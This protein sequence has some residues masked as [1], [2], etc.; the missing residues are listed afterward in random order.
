MAIL[1]NKLSSTITLALCLLFS[2]VSHADW[3]EGEGRAPILQNDTEEARRLA[4]KNALVSLMYYGGASVRS[5]QVVKSGVLQTDELRV[6]THGEVY[7]LKILK[8][9]VAED[10]V[11]VTIAADIFPSGSCH[12]NRYTKPLLVG[13]FQLEK[14]EH[15]QLGAIYDLP[16]QLGRMLYQAFQSE[17]ATVDARSLRTR[18]ITFDVSAEHYSQSAKPKDVALLAEQHGVQ[19][20]MLGKIEDLSSHTEKQ[21]KAIV[22]NKTTTKRNFRM[23][24]SV[25]DGVQGGLVFNK[26]YQGNREWPFERTVVHDVSSEAFWSSD[27]GQLVDEL[28]KQAKSEVEDALYCRQ[29]LASVLDVIGSKV[30]INLGQSNGVQLGDEFI[31]AHQQSYGNQPSNSQTSIFNV[32]ENQLDVVSVYPNRA[33]LRAK[34][35]AD[36]ANIQ[37]RDILFAMPKDPFEFDDF[38]EAVEGHLAY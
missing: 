9:A 24:I 34:R 37:V 15:A 14:Y 20:V 13:P 1:S 23:T 35:A 6:K 21:M 22:F 7:G 8:E 25:L 36:L 38:D 16:E 5:L 26:T 30:I 33:V 12:T 18:P 28:L 19:Y 10:H 29:S 17:S 3:F 27:Y 31:L 4:V 32:T 11:V 2:A